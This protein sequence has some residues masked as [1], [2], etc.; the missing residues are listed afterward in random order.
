MSDAKEIWKGFLAGPRVVA[1]ASVALLGMAGA[2]LAS[3]GLG[4]EGVRAVIR[5]TARTSLLLF[6]ASFAASSLQR[7]LRRPATAWMLR[8]RRYLGL[9][10]AVSHAIHLAAILVL[11]FGFPS[12]YREVPITTRVGGTLGFVVIAVM[13]ATSNDRSVA[14]LGG[15]RWR[16]IH[17]T[18]GWILWVVFAASYLPAIADPSRTAY[19]ALVLA[20]AGVRLGAWARSRAP[21]QGTTARSSSPAS[22]RVG[23]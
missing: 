9:S 1:V 23:Q 13:A 8:N 22:S 3:A 17:R 2:L 20:V 7:L 10:F 11:A 4:E 15:R 21:R 19:A 12:E 6:A 16:A 18:G 5:A 14:W